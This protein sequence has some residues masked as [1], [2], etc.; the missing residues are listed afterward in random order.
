MNIIEA[1]RTGECIR[2]AGKVA[3]WWKPKDGCY[4]MVTSPDDE[5]GKRDTPIPLM[6]SHLEADYETWSQ[7][8]GK[9]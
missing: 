8:H 9:K 1:A 3:M 5:I 6:Q 7:V 2:K 4:Y